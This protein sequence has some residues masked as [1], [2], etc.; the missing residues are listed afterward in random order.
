MKSNRKDQLKVFK[1]Y[2]VE[3]IKTSVNLKLKGH[4]L[5]IDWS[6]HVLKLEV[7]LYINGWN[8][9][10]EDA[11][12]WEDVWFERFNYENKCEMILNKIEEL[13]N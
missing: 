1:K 6:P 13:T 10:R 5:F 2:G 4:D 9:E 11:D 12:L 8:S 3:L 7:R